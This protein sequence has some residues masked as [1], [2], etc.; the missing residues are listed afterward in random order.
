MTKP[1][2]IKREV[3]GT[4]LTY[5]ELDT[6][7][8]NLDDATINFV[9]DAGDTRSMDL[10]DTTTFQGDHNLKITVDE[11]TQKIIIDN[12]L[13]EYTQE[14]M[15]F[16]NR[17]DSAISFNDGTRTFTIA[18]TGASFKIWCKGTEYTKTS[19]ESVSVPNTTDLYFI[20]YDNTATLQYQTDYF[21]FDQ[22]TPVA[23]VYWNATTG[24]SYFFA[25]ER[26]GITLDWATHEYL[27]RT[28]GAAFASGFVIS[29]Y[30]TLGSGSLDSDAQFDLSGGTFFDEDIKI[31]I[32]HS[33]TPSA[34]FEQTLQ[35]PSEIPMAYKL[36]ASA[37]WRVDTATDFAVKQGTSY[38]AYN[39]NTAGVWT[40]PDVGN[41]KY[42]VTWI[43]ATN[44]L[45]EPVIGIL[46]QR[47]DVNISNAEDGNTW[48][49]LDLDGFPSQEFRPLYR[50]MWQAGGSN[51]PHCYLVAVLDYRQGEIRE[52]AA[53]G[54]TTGL[55]EVVEDTSP[56]LGGNLDTNGY[57]IVSAAGSPNIVVNPYGTG[58]IYLTANY[59]VAGETDGHITGSIGDDLTLRA[60]GTPTLLSTSAQ[61]AIRAG[62]NGGIELT[63][64][65]TGEISLNSI[66]KFYPTTGTPTTYEN[67]YYQ[68]MLQTPVSWLKINIGG[69]YYYIP[70][71]Q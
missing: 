39:L 65:G 57:Q 43:V 58:Y 41:N 12:T 3:K 18:P 68:D 17:T 36:G 53:V 61:V 27:H 21:D 52:A 5:Q 9:G 60:G 23:Y 20:Y 64:N 10:N 6:N 19:S 50:L 51:T 59:V 1:V 15:G 16:E 34:D 28:R 25:E 38:P 4:P 29:N 66:V 2:I 35:G 45:S 70:L 71:F 33:A 67:G 44:N 40:T 14:P 37:E 47:E 62:T 56:Q 8:Q 32:T 11:A 42:F 30:T 48:E 46:G 26:H 49:A 54:T 24:Q 13:H 22:E 7:F 55:G 31:Q 63:P 69:S